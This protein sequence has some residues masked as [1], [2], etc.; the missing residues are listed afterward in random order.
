M[1]TEAQIRR[2]AERA[3]RGGPQGRTQGTRWLEWQEQEAHQEEGLSLDRGERWLVGS[4]QA[5]V[6]VWAAFRHTANCDVTR[7]SSA[8]TSDRSHG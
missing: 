7:W 6:A 3:E 5:P 2:A 1:P 8:S 4:G